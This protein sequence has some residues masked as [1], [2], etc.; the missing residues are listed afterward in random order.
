MHWE[1]SDSVWDIIL[2]WLFFRRIV[3]HLMFF[4][5]HPVFGWLLIIEHSVIG[6]LCIKHQWALAYPMKV[7][8]KIN[9]I[10]II[11]INWLKACKTVTNW[12]KMHQF[13]CH[14]P[15]RISCLT[16]DISLHRWMVAWF[17]SPQ[18]A[19]T[20][21]FHWTLWKG[22]KSLSTAPHYMAAS[23]WNKVTVSLHK[24]GLTINYCN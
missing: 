2:A 23:I 4:P 21:I 6:P 1:I 19:V 22:K 17:P 9:S 7:Y 5:G 18:I 10:Q 14:L 11:S 12:L 13:W 8:T 3:P 24:F 20:V 15:V 16:Q